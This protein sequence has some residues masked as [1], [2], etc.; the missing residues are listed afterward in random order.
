MGRKVLLIRDLPACHMC[1][2]CVSAEGPGVS[3]LTAE[4]Q[5]ETSLACYLVKF[6]ESRLPTAAFPGKLFV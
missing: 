5:L 3:W 1:P 2:G 4:A 6:Q